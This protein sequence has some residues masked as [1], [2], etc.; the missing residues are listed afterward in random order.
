MGLNLDKYL[1]YSMNKQVLPFDLL[2]DLMKYL[3]N[4]SRL[5]PHIYP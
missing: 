5:F 2:G 3:E 1:K 4:L